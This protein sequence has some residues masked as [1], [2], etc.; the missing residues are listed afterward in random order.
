MIDE[1]YLK[2]ENKEPVEWVLPSKG[3]AFFVIK[4]YSS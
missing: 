1:T 4:Y 2:D 3:E